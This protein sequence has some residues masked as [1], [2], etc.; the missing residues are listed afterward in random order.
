[1]F[2][3]AKYKKLSLINVDPRTILIGSLS[4][5]TILINKIYIPNRYYVIAFYA[6]MPTKE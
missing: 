1:M 2:S 4:G 5:L 3:Y 6:L